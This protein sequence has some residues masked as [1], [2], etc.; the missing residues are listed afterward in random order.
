MPR[1][2]ARRLALSQEDVHS[3]WFCYDTLSDDEDS[4]PVVPTVPPAALPVITATQTGRGEDR[5]EDEGPVAFRC[6]PWGYPFAE[7]KLTR[8]ELRGMAL[9]PATASAFTIATAAPQGDG[10]DGTGPLLDL[11]NAGPDP[12]AEVVVIGD[13]DGDGDDDDD[14]VGDDDDVAD[15]GY[16][17]YN[18]AV[19]DDVRMPTTWTGRG[20]TQNQ[21]TNLPGAVYQ[22]VP[23]ETLEPEMGPEEV[24]GA[25]ADWFYHGPDVVFRELNLATHTLVCRTSTKPH[26]TGPQPTPQD[27]IDRLER[28][29]AGLAEGA[30]AASKRSKKRKREALLNPPG[31]GSGGGAVKRP[32]FLLRSL[33]AH[34]EV[35][36]L[37]LDQALKPGVPIGLLASEWDPLEA[38]GADL[39]PP[40]ASR[41]V[42]QIVTQTRRALAQS[43]SIATRTASKLLQQQHHHQLQLQLQLQRDDRHPRSRSMSCSPPTQ[44]SAQR[45]SQSR[46]PSAS[47]SSMSASVSPSSRSRSHSRSRSRSRSHSRSSASPFTGHSLH[48]RRPRHHHRRSHHH[49][50]RQHRS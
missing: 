43:A 45:D 40:G 12:E 35:G 33:R 49:R 13:G 5:D 41:K 34:P 47:L 42:H 10:A 44:R 7:I 29:V 1:R 11:V 20:L 37:V 26:R 2:K 17:P 24:L 8:T 18:L 15:A 50:R 23:L 25:M 4:G 46:S 19:Q 9:P 6:P 36:P 48:A 31:G 39:I 3:E 14:D 38:L 27:R 28:V 22:T 21:G 30:A 32:P 16:I